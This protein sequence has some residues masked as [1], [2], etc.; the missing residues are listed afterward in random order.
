MAIQQNEN[1]PTNPARAKRHKPKRGLGSA[2]TRKRRLQAEQLQD[3]IDKRIASEKEA[4]RQEI[5]RLSQRGKAES[6]DDVTR[7]FNGVMRAVT[8]DQVAFMRSLSLGHPVTTSLGKLPNVRA[9]TDFTRVVMQWPVDM[10][11]DRFNRKAVNGTVVTMKG[12]L[13]HEIGHIR[14]TTPLPEVMKNAKRRTQHPD[15]MLH[16]CWNMLEDQRMETLVV[17][18]V[19]RIKNYFGPMVAEVVMRHANDPA[20]PAGS[21]QA[22]LLLAGRKY[23]PQPVLDRTAAAFDM[24]AA[25]AGVANGADEWDRLVNNYKAASTHQQIMDATEEALDFVVKLAATMPDT[26]DDHGQMGGEN[27]EA[28]PKDSARGQKRKPG[29]KGEGEGGGGLLDR[30]KK[31]KSEKAKGKGQGEGDEDA[32][33]QSGKGKGKPSKVH[34]DEDGEGDGEHGEGGDQP[35]NALPYKPG[36]SD[37]GHAIKETDPSDIEEMLG[38]MAEQMQTEAAKDND[39]VDAIRN[40]NTEADRQGLPSYDEGHE[41]EM[42]A[43]MVAAAMFTA[44]GMEKALNSFVTQAAP[45]W[46]NRREEGIIDA[47]AYRTKGVGD[48][49]FRRQLDGHGNTELNVH[50]SMLCD[51]SGSMGG[52]YGQS[53]SKAPIVALSEALFATATACDKLG[54][55]ATYTLWSSPRQAYRVWADGNPT[56]T[57]WPTMGGTDPTD[58]L[59]DLDSHNPEEAENHLVV[60]FT[61]GEWSHTFPSLQR[62]AKPGRYMVLVRYGSYDGQMQKD[63]GADEHININDVALLPEELT[64][65]LV[66]VLSN[67]GG[68]G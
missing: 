61:D 22:W 58:A 66:K 15:H 14:F 60:I 4:A 50:V 26:V 65:A 23:L 11:P 30:F 10:I 42:P 28:D 5:A 32:D 67:G 68:W 55:G 49:D 8:G 35:M 6:K 64:K 13:Q 39:V 2:V 47:L 34:G 24:F 62:W 9:Y 18:A 52:W 56:P 20:N 57:L 17:E 3:E 43:D 45:M 31:D 54:I 63:M 51:V 59:D 38:E 1:A 21:E 40:A 53:G 33:A 7:W 27:G 46:H 12:I 41:T 37:T 25:S 19:P 36:Q 16:Q 48:R 44:T 29:Q